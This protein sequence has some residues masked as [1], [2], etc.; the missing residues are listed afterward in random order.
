MSPH[1]V[2]EVLVNICHQLDGDESDD[3]A[4]GEEEVVATLYAGNTE[5]VGMSTGGDGKHYGSRTVSAIS[6]KVKIP[7]ACKGVESLRA[8]IDSAAQ[9]TVIVLRQAKCYAHHC[10]KIFNPTTSSRGTTFIFGTHRHTALGNMEIRLPMSQDPFLSVVVEIVEPD[11]LFIIGLNTI[12]S[13][14]MVLDT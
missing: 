10:G 3:D 4:R 13:Y 9:R 2:H 5:G 1:A 12:R 14:R 8:C 6:E 7:L 11:V